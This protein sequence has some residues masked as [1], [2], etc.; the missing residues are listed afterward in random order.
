MEWCG[1]GG[2]G[3]G[4]GGQVILP[5]VLTLK[6]ERRLVPATLVSH[7]DLFEEKPSPSAHFYGLRLLAARQQRQKIDPVVRRSLLVQV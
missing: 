2:G 1:R 3:E 7:L 5:T 6:D 4:G